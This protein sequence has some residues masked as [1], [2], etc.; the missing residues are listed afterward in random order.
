MWLAKLLALLSNA[1]PLWSRLLAGLR[2]LGKLLLYP[3]ALPAFLWLLVITGSI[4]YYVKYNRLVSEAITYQDSLLYAQDTELWRLRADTLE[5][6]FEIRQLYSKLS[7]RA[8]QEVIYFERLHRADDAGLQSALDSVY[9]RHAQS[10]VQT[11]APGQSAVSPFPAGRAAGSP[12]P[13]AHPG[14]GPAGA[15]RALYGW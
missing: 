8:K 7:E 1:A 12:Q 2:W 4:T 5:A 15:F 11:A 14:R 13:D 10:A 9:H 6:N 3:V